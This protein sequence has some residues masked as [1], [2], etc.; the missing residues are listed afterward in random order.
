MQV[1]TPR[2]YPVWTIREDVEAALGAA[3]LAALDLGR[4]GQSDWVTLV[5]RN[6]PDRTRMA[7]YDELFA[8]YTALYPALNTSMHRLA[9]LRELRLVL[10][11][12]LGN[13]V[14]T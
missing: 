9:A 13:D 8:V 2:G 14:R 5:M 11:S 12:E 7:R 1:R 6:R 4:E 3:K 10:K